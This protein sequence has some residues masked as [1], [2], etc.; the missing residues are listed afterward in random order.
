[1]R[2][3]RFLI[4][5]AAMAIVVAGLATLASSAAAS[6]PLVTASPASLLFTSGELDH[7]EAKEVTLTNV[8]Q[9]YLETRLEEQD[10]G[11][12]RRRLLPEV[13]STA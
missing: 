13:I 6:V 11:A 5:A 1:M 9:R 2:K 8:T 10:V 3:P 7:A 4:R 12:L